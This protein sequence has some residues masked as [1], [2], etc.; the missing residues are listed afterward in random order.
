MKT[1]QWLQTWYSAQPIAQT[2]RDCGK[3]GTRG[4]IQPQPPRRRAELA[5]WK[6][7]A[8]CLD[9]IMASNRA[10]DQ[11]RKAQLAGEARCEVEGCE[12]R[13]QWHI[14]NGPAKALVCGAHYKRARLNWDRRHAGMAWLPAPIMTREQ[15]LAIASETQTTKE[16]EQ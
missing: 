12:R 5:G 8:L 13:G 7:Y 1:P 11:R 16:P 4:Y 14:S 6:P 3:V 15:M 2:C 10:T 9:C